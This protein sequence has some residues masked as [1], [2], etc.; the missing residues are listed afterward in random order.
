MRDARVDETSTSTT[1]N[2]ARV[3]I[4]EIVN[5]NNVHAHREDTEDHWVRSQM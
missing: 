5:D 2:V 1:K 3:S 4:N